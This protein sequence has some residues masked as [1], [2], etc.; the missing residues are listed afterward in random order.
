MC[1]SK[2]CQSSL[3]CED[4]CYSKL[5]GNVSA[6]IIVDDTLSRSIKA[7]SS[8]HVLPSHLNVLF[9]IDGTSFTI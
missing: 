3:N 6:H 1:K 9:S 2:Y 4:H 5:V 8:V 7:V